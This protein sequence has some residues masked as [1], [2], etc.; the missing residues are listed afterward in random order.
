MSLM[1]TTN[2]WVFEKIYS[3]RVKQGEMNGEIIELYT[4]NI[5]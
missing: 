3:A 4:C 5:M 2:S 1:E